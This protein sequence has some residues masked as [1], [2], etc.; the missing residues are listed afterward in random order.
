MKK[1]VLFVVLLVATSLAAMVF[2]PEQST[3]AR[4]YMQYNKAMDWDSLSTDTA[5]D[6]ATAYEYTPWY[7]LTF[8]NNLA[9]RPVAQAYW[10]V[11]AEVGS[12]SVAIRA[13]VSTMPAP[14]GSPMQYDYLAVGDPTTAGTTALCDSVQL[15]AA[16]GNGS[17]YIAVG[18]E[19]QS[20]GTWAS[21]GVIAPY[22]RFKITHLNTYDGSFR[23]DVI[24]AGD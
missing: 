19:S 7:P 15:F 23:L 8:G 24:L 16:S 5:S 20:L 21:Q 3:G 12:L 10:N 17:K 14:T 6:T 22:V 13:Q 4:L 2:I 18:I 1:L 9:D 11:T